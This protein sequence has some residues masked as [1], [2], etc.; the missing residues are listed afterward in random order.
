MD[1]EQLSAPSIPIDKLVAHRG[2]QSQF[3]ENSLLAL[4]AAIKLGASHLEIDVQLLKDL[5]PVVYHDNHLGRISGIEADL[6]QLQINDL[7]KFTAGE[8]QRLGERFIDT[9]ILTLQQ[10]VAFLNEHPTP[11]IYLEIKRSSINTFGLEQTLQAIL[12][13]IAP[14]KGRCTLISF[15]HEVLSRA[16]SLGWQHIGPIFVEWDEHFPASIIE[17]QPSI[18]F[19]NIEYIPSDFDFTTSPAPFIVYEVQSTELAQHYLNRGAYLV[20]TFMI[21]ELAG[22]V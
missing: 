7:H 12:A 16:K 9:P 4:E 13:I 2:W 10:C 8:P 1:Q 3:P 20:E 15:N 5:T 17:L 22:L 18:C 6:H 11:H 21:G 19:C 14:L